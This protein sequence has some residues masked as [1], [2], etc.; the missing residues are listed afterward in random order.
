MEGRH[1]LT[2][3]RPHRES[4]GS[5]DDVRW[6]QRRQRDGG[7]AW[8]G[9]VV[10]RHRR[11][12]IGTHP[13]G[14]HRNGRAEADVR[15]DPVLSA[16][17]VRHAVARRADDKDRA[18]RRRPD[19]CDHRIRRARLGGHADAATSFLS[20]LDDGV[21]GLRV[22]YSPDFGFVQNDPEV[23]AAVRAAV[24]V[25]ASAG[26]EVDEVE[27]GFSDP[28]RC[29]P[30]AVVLRRGQGVVVLRGDRQLGRPD[31]SGTAPHRAD[32]IRLYSLGL[33]GRHGGPDGR[34]AG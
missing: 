10:G 19:G 22:G 8:N 3:P 5:R 31:R 1:R 14:V 34:W 18:G 33:F 13:C 6:I 9:P 30:R 29:F 23:D 32:R 11:R 2:A 12:R 21:A 20:G 17:P 28:V 15:P 24:D 4:V 26:A 27:P 25:L 16:E 7:R